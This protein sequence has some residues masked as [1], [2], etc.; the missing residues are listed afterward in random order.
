MIN[1]TIVFGVPIIVLS[2][3]RLVNYGRWAGR[4]GNRRGAA[5]IY[6]IAAVCLLL[7]L[8]LIWSDSR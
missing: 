3:L 1:P 4:K 6:V 7:P 2:C 8:L 5:G